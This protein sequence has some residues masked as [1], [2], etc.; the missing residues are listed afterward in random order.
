MGRIFYGLLA[1][2]VVAAAGCGKAPEARIAAPP[3]NAAEGGE[4]TAPPGESA[5]TLG[6]AA[7]GEALA[8]RVKTSLMSRKGL[9]TGDLQVEATADGVVT[10]RGS[11]AAAEKQ[12]QVEA[13]VREVEGVSSVENALTVAP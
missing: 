13:A 9:A 2:A 3:V 6:E 12:R 8:A 7:A 1:A 4:Q 11:V 5:H 10:V